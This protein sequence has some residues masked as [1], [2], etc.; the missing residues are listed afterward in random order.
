MSLEIPEFDNID[1]LSENI[2]QPAL[3]V[4]NEYCKHLSIASINQT[5]PNKYCSFSIIKKK[6]IFD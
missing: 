4:I 3:K 6:Y 5:F 2:S 1:Q